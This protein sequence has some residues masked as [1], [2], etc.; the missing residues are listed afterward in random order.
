MG[1]DPFQGAGR[2]PLIHLARPMEF[3]GVQEDAI[4]GDY[5]FL[6]IPPSPAAVTTHIPKELVYRGQPNRSLLPNHCHPISIRSPFV[7]CERR[8]LMYPSRIS[9]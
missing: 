9:L 8:G 7:G 5:G 4:L 6:M 2:M 3:F 1:I